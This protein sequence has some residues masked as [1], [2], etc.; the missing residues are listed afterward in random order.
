MKSDYMFTLDKKDIY[1]FFYLEQN[2]SNCY[3][4]NCF[5]RML[6]LETNNKLDFCLSSLR[7]PQFTRI[8]KSLDLEQCLACKKKNVAK[9]YTTEVIHL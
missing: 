6:P 8:S 2:L 9:N 1:V 4:E 7:P 3:I 5:G